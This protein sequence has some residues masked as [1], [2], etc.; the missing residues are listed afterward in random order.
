MSKQWY[1]TINGNCLE[2]MPKLEANS[3][4][5]IVT[6]PPY[7][8]SDNS[9]D[10]VGKI[11]RDVVFPYL[12][13]FY[14]QRFCNG[15]L[16]FPSDSISLLDWVNRSIGIESG[17]GVP[18]TTLDFNSNVSVGNEK[19]KAGGKST[20][21]VSDNILVNEVDSTFGEFKENFIL[22]LRP[23][24]D[25]SVSDGLAGFL[26][27]DGLGCF[28]VPIVISHDSFFASFLRTLS[29]SGSGFLAD[30]I[31]FLNNT[32]S[33]PLTSS[34]VMTGFGAVITAML[35]FDMRRR[36]IELLPTDSTSKSDFLGF[37]TPPKFIGANSGTSSLPSKFESSQFSFVG[38]STNRTC[39]FYFHKA[40]YVYFQKN[41]K[42]FM[43]KNWDHGVPGEAFWSE[44]LRV[45]KPG[46]HLLAFGGTRTFHRLA[47]A[48]EDAGWEIRDTI[49]WVYGSGFPKSQ[50]I[51]KQIDK[52]AD[53]ER[54]IVGVKKHPTSKNGNRTGNK[55]PYQAIGN[56]DGSYN[57]TTPAT[58]EA[59]KWDGWGTALKP[60]FEPIIV[61][62]KPVEKSIT[63][64]V[65]KWGT[66][67]IN[68][69]ECRIVVDTEDKNHRVNPSPH[70]TKNSMFGVGGHNG[71]LKSQGRW[72]ANLI[73]DGS[74]EV[75]ELF[76]MTTSGGGVKANTGKETSGMFGF[77]YNNQNS[78]EKNSGSAARFF[79]CAKA[80]KADRGENNNHPT[81]KPTD[82]M[83]YLVRLIT[84]PNGIVFDPF[85]GSG[86]TGKAAMYEDK[87]FIGIEMEQEYINMAKERIKYAKKNKTNTL[88]E[89]FK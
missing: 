36:T 68:I 25:F 82:L 9:G 69:D 53:A 28:R 76:P 20:Q 88:E 2:E 89:F 27:E 78:F 84:P 22:N 29:P 21:R 65:L 55:N 34:S 83:R 40:I 51:S 4:D 12:T 47:V 3:V 85:M 64:N 23:S 67:A 61:A 37:V 77:I 30:V 62:R 46:A 32:G 19:I 54:K 16:P 87:N 60:S 73:H 63:K 8:L 33:K 14:T 15:E 72:P 42:G 86:S 6:D 13:D 35:R 79:Y 39:S 49:S 38:D 45:A 31:R 43:G 1:K 50:N 17:I 58:N 5:S 10:S 56:M 71:N 7:G 18:E 11:M 26:R 81:V 41:R 24:G 52:I 80:S 66:G 59:E 74:D 48:I 57:I 75:M 44:V 70:N